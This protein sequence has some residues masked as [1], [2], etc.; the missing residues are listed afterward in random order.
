MN[1][2]SNKVQL[3]GNIGQDP[4]IKTFDNGNK[5]ARMSLATSEKRKDATGGY[6]TETTW[7]NIVVWGKQVD[8]IEKYV[9]KGKEILVEGKIANR[10][11]LDKNND[12]RYITEIVV[13]SF[14]L[15]GAKEA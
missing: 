13:Q 9:H 3:I 7:H 12:K 2:H 11:Y 14:K 8:V 15:L 4:E 1:S 10:S 6:I 5:V